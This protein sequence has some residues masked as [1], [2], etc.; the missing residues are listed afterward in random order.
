MCRSVGKIPQGNQGALAYLS[1]GILLRRNEMLILPWTARATIS[2]HTHGCL[3]M[4]TSLLLLAT[5]LH[6]FVRSLLYGANINHCAVSRR[7]ISFQ[8]DASWSSTRLSFVQIVFL[9][10]RPRSNDQTRP[11][12]PFRVLQARGQQRAP[13]DSLIRSQQNMRNPG[14]LLAWQEKALHITLAMISKYMH[15]KT[16]HSAPAST[17]ESHS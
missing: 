2:Y 14:T 5:R 9:S 6:V 1:S 17:L 3:H 16:Y 8:S 4:S 12:T 13:I 10:S 15:R 11:L 7:P